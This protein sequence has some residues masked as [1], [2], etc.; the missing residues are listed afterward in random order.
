MDIKVVFT[1]QPAQNTTPL[2]QAELFKG[3]AGY[4]LA[5]QINDRLF[6]AD[7]LGMINSIIEEGR[8]LNEQQVGINSENLLAALKDA[9]IV[10]E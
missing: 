6:V 3:A 9:K 1:E 7:V 10:A 5:I 4:K 2:P 8:R